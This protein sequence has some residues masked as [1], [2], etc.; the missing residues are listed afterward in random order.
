MKDKRNRPGKTGYV[1]GI[2]V[3]AVGQILAGVCQAIAIVLRSKGL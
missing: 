3:I 1:V 2:I